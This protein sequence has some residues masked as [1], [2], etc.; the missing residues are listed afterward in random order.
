MHMKLTNIGFFFLF[1]KGVCFYWV[2]VVILETRKYFF[3][4]EAI[5]VLFYLFFSY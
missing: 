4:T 3:N 1:L 5:H 2:R